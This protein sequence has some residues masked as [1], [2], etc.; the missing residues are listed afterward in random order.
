MGEVELLIAGWAE[1]SLVD[2]IG[3]VSFTIWFCG[4]DFRCPWCQNRPVVLSE[5]GTCRKVPLREV[6]EAISGASLLSDYV[7]ATGGEP[8]LQPEGLKALFRACKDELGLKT[9]LDTNGSMASVVKDLL[10]SGLVDH[11]AMDIK[12][13]LDQP[14]KYGRVAGIGRE[15]A[16]RAVEAIRASLSSALDMAPFLEVRTTFVPGLISDQDVLAIARDLADTGLNR[17]PRAYY[18]LQ[19]FSPR[20]SLIDPSFAEL[21]QPTPEE[22]LSLARLVKEQTGLGAVY[23]RAQ[24]MGVVK[25]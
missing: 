22:L 23:V 19:Q 16:L 10:A 4:C 21:A 11:L 8:T 24:E 18:V 25:V 3:E 9:S 20:G 1:S 15:K 12:A 6:L 2:I 5:P 13:P 14:G 7:Q 17:R